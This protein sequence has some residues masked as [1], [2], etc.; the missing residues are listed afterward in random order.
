MCDSFT[1]PAVRLALV[2][3]A[4]VTRSRVAPP[5]PGSGSMRPHRVQFASSAS[6]TIAAPRG[7]AGAPAPTVAHSVVPS[8]SDA[9]APGAP[10][11]STVRRS[12]MPAT[13]ARVTTL[14]SVAGASVS[15]DGSSSATMLPE[16]W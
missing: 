13:C 2:V 16:R 5:P 14:G 15:I 8:V 3:A 12:R 10:G 4:A 9:T 6:G 11:S 7:R 1:E